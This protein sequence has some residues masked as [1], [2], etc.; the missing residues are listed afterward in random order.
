LKYYKGNTALVGCKDK[1]DTSNTRWNWTQLKIIQKIHEQ[2]NGKAG[3]Q[4]TQAQWALITY[5]R[6]KRTKRKITLH[7]PNIAIT[8]YLK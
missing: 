8:E 2:R 7:V 1:Y 4:G 6:E 3:N 5:F